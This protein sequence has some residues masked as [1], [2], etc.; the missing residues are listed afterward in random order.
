MTNEVQVPN[1][2]AVDFFKQQSQTPVAA[3][4]IQQFIPYLS[5]GYG[6]SDAVLS[7]KAQLG[8]FILGGNTALG[9]SIKVVAAAYRPHASVWDDAGK[10]TLMDFYLK[11]GVVPSENPEWQKFIK[12]ALPPTQKMQIGVDILLWLVDQSVFTQMF[13][14]NTLY[15]AFAGLWQASANGRAVEL[16]TEG[17][18][19]KKSGNVFYKIN[20]IPLN[21]AIVGSSWNIPGINIDCDINIPLEFLMSATEKFSTFN[22]TEIETENVGSRER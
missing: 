2:S 3:P 13:M 12:Q 19:A 4:E 22:N 17:I 8:E 1:S 9:F 10:S 11:Q 18:R 20:T 6:S 5:I 15:S 7:R 16:A 21:R 14:K